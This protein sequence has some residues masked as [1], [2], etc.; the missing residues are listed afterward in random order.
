MSIDLSLLPPPTIIQDV[1]HDEIVAR[2]QARFEQFWQAI[3][4]AN[5]SA[6][7][8]AYDVSMLETDPAVIS[9]QAESFRETLLRARINGAVRALLLAFARGSDL[10]HLAAFY[11]VYRMAGED[12][13]RFLV[14]IILGIQ[15]RSTG[16]TE[17]RYRYVAMSADLS[18]QAA[19]VYR[20]RRSPL[21]H[22]AVYSTAPDGVASPALL[23]KV[24]A[25]LQ[26][27]EVIMVND[28][29]VVA[30][31]VR[32]IVSLQADVWLLPDAPED[33]LATAE[34]NLRSAWSTNRALGRDLVET[35]WISKLMVGGVHRLAAVTSGDLIAEPHEAISIGTV[36]LNDRGRAF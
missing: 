3:R 13:D 30:S 24:D 32:K 16:G 34:A 21:I 8:P 23:A 19:I 7:L 6:D 31:A 1:S 29:I 5:P 17:P 28:T 12:D 20:V 9:N 27:P 15:G 33:T 14:R 36:K 2:Q 11:D 4:V 18:V 25:A 22:V 35:W 26:D 10:E